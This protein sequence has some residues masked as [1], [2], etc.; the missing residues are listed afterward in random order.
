MQQL[1]KKLKT[2]AK[3]LWSKLPPKSQS[4]SS[5]ERMARLERNYL[6]LLKRMLEMDG[7]KLNVTTKASN[8]SATIF[9]TSDDNK[10]NGLNEYK[11]T[12]H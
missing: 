5:A 3:N 8:M 10:N 9:Q 12:I 7:V 1:I 6:V 11:P 2:I 4:I